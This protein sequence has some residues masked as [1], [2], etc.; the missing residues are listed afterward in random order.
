MND[1]CE[2]FIKGPKNKKTP[3]IYIG[4]L[5]LCVFAAFLAMAYFG[6]AGLL[7]SFLIA[8]GGAYVCT[9]VVRYFRIEYE[10]SVMGSEFSISVIR[11]QSKRKLLMSCEIKDIGSFGRVSANDAF[12]AC[13]EAKVGDENRLCCINEAS[14]KVYYFTVRANDGKSYRVYIEPNEKMLELLEQRSMEVKRVLMRGVN[15]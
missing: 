7:M 4:I 10:Y 9:K 12:E 6:I 1:K 13:R 2:I 11:N 8:L 14:E 15:A 5:I 3:L